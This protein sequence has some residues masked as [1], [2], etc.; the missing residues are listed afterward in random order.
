MSAVI[1]ASTAALLGTS[2]EP[3]DFHYTSYTFER[4]GI[5]G[6]FVELTRDQPSATFFVTVHVDDLGPDSV[7]T[8]SGA[9]VNIDGSFVTTGL[10]EGEVVPFVS[11][12]VSSPDTTETSEQFILDHYVQSHPLIFT[13]DCANPKAGSAACAAH[14]AVELT[15]QDDA[16]P[17]VVRFDWLFDVHAT[18]QQSAQKDSMV[19]PVDPPWTIEVSQP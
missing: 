6:G 19:G 4:T 11:V 2:A 12:K 1:A 10:G 14:F 13:G 16:G 18:A 5:D 8:S 15:R 7:V 9:S 3:P 17:G